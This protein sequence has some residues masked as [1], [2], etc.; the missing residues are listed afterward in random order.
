VSH[1]S[2][3]KFCGPGTAHVRP[4]QQARF[5]DKLAHIA[6]EQDP[7]IP[8]EHDARG[9]SRHQVD[10]V[11]CDHKSRSGTGMHEI[12]N[13]MAPSIATRGVFSSPAARSRSNVRSANATNGSATSAQRRHH[14]AERTPSA[15]CIARAGAAA[16]VITTNANSA[17]RAFFVGCCAVRGVA[18]ERYRS[19]RSARRNPLAALP[20]QALRKWIFGYFTVTRVK[21]AP[22]HQRSERICVSRWVGLGK[23]F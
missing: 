23:V 14:R 5:L 11:R 3:P 2:S 4:H 16:S 6:I 1:D 7:S 8:K 21:S 13:T 20:K 22:G 19:H 10:R 9:K 15:R 12:A 18:C 17:L